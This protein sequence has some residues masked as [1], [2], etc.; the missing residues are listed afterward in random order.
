MAGKKIGYSVEKR[1]IKDNKVISSQT[2]H[3]SISRMGIPVTIDVTQK[4]T[5]T[6]DGKPLS[7]DML[8]NFSLMSTHIFGTI[9]D[10]VI[11][12]STETMGSIQKSQKPW[13]KGAVMSEGFRLIQKKHGLRAGTQYTALVFSPDIMKTITMDVLIGPKKNIDLLGRIIK[14]TEIQTTCIMPGAGKIKTTIY[15]DNNL[16]AQKTIMPIMGMNMEMIACAKEFALKKVESPE[17]FINSTLPSPKPLGDLSKIRAITYQII[18]NTKNAELGIPDTD[19]QT[20]K[21]LT[22]GSISLT[23]KPVTALKG[24]SFPY[25]GKNKEALTALESNMYL[26]VNNPRVIAL[27]RKAVGNTTDTALAVKKIEN[28]VG[29][30][31][32]AKGLSVGYASALEVIESKQGDCSEHAVLAAALCRAIGIPAQV[33]VGVTYVAEFKG[34]KNCFGGH[35]WTRA[36]IKDKWVDFDAT[37]KGTGRGGFEAGHIALAIGNGE[38]GDFFAMVN[39]LGK[40]KIKSIQIKPQQQESK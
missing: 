40:F 2:M 36:L 8:Q 19:C 4:F 20:V 37:F 28:F 15:A 16:N 34:G 6:C 39:S 18:P 32:T 35:A 22:D 3:I 1:N 12:I 24:G 17:M 10:E 38:P 29:Q 11:N 14:L 13:P 31:I 7:F 25:Q 9:K 26:Q 5:E 23:V 33:V 21:P 30:Y 27:A